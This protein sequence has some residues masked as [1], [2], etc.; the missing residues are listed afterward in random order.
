MFEGP[1]YERIAPLLDAHGWDAGFFQQHYRDAWVAEFAGSETGV[2]A[3]AMALAG[4]FLTVERRFDGRG[5]QLAH[6]RLRGHV[7]KF[8]TD[9]EPIDFRLVDL[10]AT[11]TPDAFSHWLS[12]VW[13]A[14]RAQHSDVRA[15]VDSQ[16]ADAPAD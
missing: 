9:H 16:L 2:A 7:P 3:L 1:D 5:V 11:P 10:A 4:L 6:G 8:T 13:T 15:W 14:Y 12:A